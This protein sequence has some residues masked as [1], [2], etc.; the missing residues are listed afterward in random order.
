MNKEHSKLYFPFFRIWHV[1]I[2][3]ILIVAVYIS[4]FGFRFEWIIPAQH[5]KQFWQFL[6]FIPFIRLICN[7]IFGM[8]QHLWQYFGIREM[9]GIIKSATAGSIIFILIVYLTGNASFPRSIFLFEWALIVI[10]LGGVRFSRRFSQE[11][12][13]IKNKQMSRTLIIGAGDAGEMLVRE[14]L[15]HPENGL[16]PV[17]FIDDNKSKWR[18]R[19]HGIK[20]F[21]SREKIPEIVSGYEI[22]VIVLSIPSAQPKVLRELVD[23]CT[24]TNAKIQIVPAIHEIIDGT[25][26][27]SHVRQ[28]KLEDLLGREPIVI[29]DEEVA[30]LIADKNIMVTGAGGSIGS[31]LCRQLAYYKPSMLYLVGHGENSIYK[32]SN[33]LSLKFPELKIIKI[34][35]DIRHEIHLDSIFKEYQPRIIFHTAAHKHLP[36]MEEN[37]K[38]SISNNVIG[39]YILTKLAHKYNIER[40]VN[41]STDKAVNPVSIMG[42]TKRLA[43]LI[44]QNQKSKNITKFMT[45]RFGNVIGS[46]GS[47]IPL[48]EDQIRKGGPVTVTHPDMTRYFMTIPEAVQLVLQASI[49]GNGSETF[50]LD[51]GDPVN[52]LELAKNMVRLSGFSE[53][54]ISIVFTGVRNGEKI[55]EE[56][57]EPSQA[58]QST[59]YAKIFVCQSCEVDLSALEQD[60]QNLLTELYNFDNAIIKNRLCE[61]IDKY[62]IMNNA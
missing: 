47:V 56:L 50:I 13:R 45:V 28:L 12:T 6:P 15:R 59:K 31:E 29:N 60:I 10:A 19:I 37:I 32:I 4:V 3:Y 16:L 52:I 8:Y 27:I 36:L 39:T 20:V 46:R 58:H 9:I 38:E 42:M 5:L 24:K 57:I 17:G 54:E 43:E 41:I 49:L 14:M 11:I 22:D 62:S 18:A 23:I 48:F 25:V 51:M 40:F 53:E 7:Y 33:E 35:V 1:L 26:S 44:I 30:K 21:G 2:D 55:H 61:L 34:I